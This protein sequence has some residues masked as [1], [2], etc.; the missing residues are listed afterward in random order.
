MVDMCSSC[1]ICKVLKGKYI[2]IFYLCN[3]SKLNVF[4][5]LGKKTLGALGI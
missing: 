4:S 1:N 3:G 2:V 5:V